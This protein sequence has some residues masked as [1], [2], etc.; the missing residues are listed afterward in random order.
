MAKYNARGKKVKTKEGYILVYCPE[1]PKAKNGKY[2]Y[3]HRLKMANYLGR[4]LEEREHV[5]HKNGNK[6]DNRIENLELL[7][8]SEHHKKHWKEA[9]Q[10]ERNRISK[11]AVAYQKAHKRERKMI[12]CACGCGRML[13]NIDDHNRLRKYIHGH[14]SSRRGKRYD[15]QKQN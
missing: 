9:T 14:N 15:E 11:E 1:Y 6:Q 7:T 10:E 8:N 4:P 2:V 13:L 5:H 12:Y 3:E